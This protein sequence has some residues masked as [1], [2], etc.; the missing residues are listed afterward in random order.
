MTFGYMPTLKDNDKLFSNDI[1]KSNI[2]QRQYKS[3]W[4]KFSTY[5]NRRYE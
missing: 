4:S 1:D 5:E 3:M 2:L